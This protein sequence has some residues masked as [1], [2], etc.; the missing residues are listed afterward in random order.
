MTTAGELTPAWE[1]WSEM[2]AR[3]VINYMNGGGLALISYSAACERLKREGLPRRRHRSMEF[4]E[5]TP[6]RALKS[7]LELSALEKQ[8]LAG[9]ELDLPPVAIARNCL[10]SVTLVD[11]ITERLRDAGVI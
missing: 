4:N 3:S 6:R 1:T 7:K 11:D 2:A 8:V 5:N 10:V 9:L